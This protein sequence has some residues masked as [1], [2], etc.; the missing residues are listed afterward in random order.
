MIAPRIASTY[1]L[2]FRA[3][4]AQRARQQMLLNGREIRLVRHLAQAVFFQVSVGDVRPCHSNS[5]GPR[6]ACTQGNLSFC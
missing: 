5:L 3:F 4:D 6:R 2:A 1:L